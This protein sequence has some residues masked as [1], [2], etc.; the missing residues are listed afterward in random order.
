MHSKSFS[1]GLLLILLSPCLI[2]GVALYAIHCAPCTAEKLALCPPVPA[3]CS[4]TA[5]QPGCGCCYICALQLGEPCGVHTARCVQGLS[6]RVHPKEANPLRA[7]NNGQGTCLPPTDV[8]EPTVSVEYEDNPTEATEVAAD[9]LRN[10]QL[11]LPAGQEKP[12]SR[13]AV[14]VYESMEAKKLVE[15]HKWKTQG[16]CQKELYRALDKLAK[17]QQRTGGE[18]YRFYLPNCNRNGFYH[19]KQ[20]EASL[21]GNPATCWCVYQ[22]SGKRIPGSPEVLGDPECEQY[23][24]E[25]E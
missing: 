24:G 20:C 15:V 21:D 8:T 22:R 3:S 2:F 7:L 4:E 9:H 18:I 11:M 12:V 25:Q 16:P 19:R 14:S 1:F 5:R 6:C 23:L 10:Y 17:T 13:K